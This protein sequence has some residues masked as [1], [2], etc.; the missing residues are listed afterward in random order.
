MEAVSYIMAPSLAGIAVAIT[1]L[2]VGCGS[3]G[4]G[5]RARYRSETGIREYFSRPDLIARQ[6]A[7]SVAELERL[8]PVLDELQLEDVS[9]LLLGNDAKGSYRMLRRR[10]GKPFDR[11]RSSELHQLRKVARVWYDPVLSIDS[12]SRVATFSTGVGVYFDQLLSDSAMIDVMQRSGAVQ[13]LR[14]PDSR[15]WYSAEF[16]A[17]IGEGIVDRAEWFT[18]QP[19]VT[20]S[21]VIVN[22]P[23]EPIESDR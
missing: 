23:G 4:E 17:S 9:D 1:I 2:Q 22:I 6:S 5:I 21:Y 16:D 20:G 8:R 14:N 15:F 3:A 7:V 19:G 18:R 12:P 13:Y 10:D 11:E